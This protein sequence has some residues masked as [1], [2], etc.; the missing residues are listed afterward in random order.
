MLKRLGR[1]LRRGDARN[2][3][4]RLSHASLKRLPSSARGVAKEQEQAL[5]E[6]RVLSKVEHPHIVRYFAS[7]VD[8]EK[9]H[10]VMEF[11]EGGDL[12]KAIDARKDN[13]GPVAGAFPEQTIWRYL[14]HIF[15]GLAH[16]HSLKVLHRDMK[17]S[18]LFLK[19]GV[20]VLGTLAARLLGATAELATTFV[21]TP[22]YCPPSC[23]IMRTT[24]PHP[25]CGQWAWSR[26]S[27]SRVVHTH[28]LPTTHLRSS[29]ASCAGARPSSAALLLRVARARRRAA[30]PGPKL[31]PTASGCSTAHP[32]VPRR[33]AA[34]AA[35]LPPPVRCRRPN[36]HHLRRC[37]RPNARPA[38]GVAPPEGSPR[39]R[40]RW[41]GA[42][43][44]RKDSPSSG[45]SHPPPERKAVAPRV[46]HSHGPMA[47]RRKRQ[48][49]GGGNQG[50]S[51]VTVCLLPLARRGGGTGGLCYCC[52]G[53]RKWR[54]RATPW[55]GTDGAC[56]CRHG[57]PIRGG[58]ASMTRGG[59]R[60]EAV[61]GSVDWRS[62]GKGG[63][64]LVTAALAAHEAR[65]ADPNTDTD[66]DDDDGGVDASRAAAKLAIAAAKKAIIKPGVGALR[67]LGRRSAQSGG[68]G[69]SRIARA[70]WR[71]VRHCTAA[72]GARRSRGDYGW[73]RWW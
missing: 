7:F 29:C 21:G 5:N 61:G 2:T 42:G 31:R 28:S 9:L 55:S 30:P 17:S 11:C 41:R 36:A 64:D 65:L 32:K 43:R 68:R 14:S 10:I 56:G 59:E 70:I 16:L 51:G 37:T 67:A 26:S 71:T 15:D 38:R 8:K 20:V 24:A 35:A 66:D 52:E 45:R 25:T 47:M 60:A 44:W 58:W 22:Y 62:Q 46:V 34:D 73:R 1:R 72:N 50:E 39:P 6:V 40:R 12:R 63:A 13:L 57:R 4:A 69:Q 49:D 54:P 27:C 19:R 18:N 48:Q 33:E 23:A 53:A 3:Q